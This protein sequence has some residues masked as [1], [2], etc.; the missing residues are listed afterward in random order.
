M[1]ILMFTNTFTPHVG[2]VARSVAG[3]A[4]AFRAAGH[5]VVVVAPRFEGTPE[6]EADV[7][8]FPA[9]QN[10]NGSDFSVPVPVPGILA[11]T[12]ED[13]QPDLVHS[14][15]PFLL[16]DTALRVAATRNVPV[17]FTHH[18]MYENYTHYVPGDSPQMRRFAID[19]ATGYCNLCDAVI[20]PSETVAGILRERGVRT[21]VEVV[22][23][24]VD[25]AAFRRGDRAA[26][27]RRA[28]IAADRFVVGHVGRLAPEKN[29]D[30][31]AGALAR[32]AARD[33]RAHVLIAG[34]GPSRDAIARAFEAEA[35]SD[36]LALVGVLDRPALADLYRALDVFAFASLTETQ[37][38]VVAEAMAAGVPVV[39]LDAAGVR[40]VVRDRYNGRLLARPD[41]D[42]FLAALAW[43]R[44]LD[45]NARDRLLAGVA[46]TAQRYSIERTARRAL[47]LYADLIRAGR[48][49]R[50]PG[51]DLWHTAQRRLG[52]EWKIVRNIAAAVG[53]A[54]LSLGREREER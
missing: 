5:R 20:A 34:A 30:F 11:A 14:H 25:L 45:R 4:A 13:L 53:D 54:W 42:A 47:A 22:P 52:E 8:R 35:V 31:L 10:F 46:Q 39:A 49:E 15:H 32:F 21:R 17:V 44:G 1:N 37:G 6:D 50:H 9:V 18:T 24:G 7:V 2:G 23:T 29:L 33:A 12:V 40:E 3:F 19:L 43:V 48:A 28:G 16:G 51:D 26:G 27:R 38:L 41:T 36:R